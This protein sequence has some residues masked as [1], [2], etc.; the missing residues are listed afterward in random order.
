MYTYDNM[1]YY[2]PSD[3]FYMNNVPAQNM[4]M[5]NQPVMNDNKL[6]EKLKKQAGTNMNF[7]KCNYVENT[8]NMYDAYNGFIHGNMFS[9]LYNSYKVKPY[10]IRP[11]NEQAELLT[12]IDTY[13]FAA[14]DINLYLDTNPGDKELIELYKKYIDEMNLAI[15]EYEQKYGPLFVDA[16]T[17]PWTWNNSPWPWEN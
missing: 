13:C 10:D 15:K 1:N 11:M 9:D 6:K 12:Y 3:Y 14:H 8:N 16:S 4:V 7:N 5:N 17:Y 2:V